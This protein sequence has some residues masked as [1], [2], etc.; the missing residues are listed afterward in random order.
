MLP[1]AGSVLE[2]SGRIL[3]D[4]L[5]LPVFLG[6][7]FDRRHRPDSYAGHLLG[8]RD[9]AEYLPFHF[10]MPIVPLRARLYLT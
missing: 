3:R 2:Q 10:T 4:V 5:R 8:L 6:N 9:L 1:F 7:C